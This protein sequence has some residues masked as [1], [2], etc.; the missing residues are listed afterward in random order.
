MKV[1]TLIPYWDKYEYENKA[2]VDRCYNER[3]EMGK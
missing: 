2:L 3:A 1:V